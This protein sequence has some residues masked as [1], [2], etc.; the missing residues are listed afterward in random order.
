MIAQKGLSG[1]K[2]IE[3]EGG[4]IKLFDSGIITQEIEKASRERESNISSGRT[5]I[6]GTN[7]FPNGQEEMLDMIE[8]RELIP[9]IGNGINL[10]RASE[11]FEKLRLSTEKVYKK[12]GKKP[13]VFLLPMGN[14]AIRRARAMFATNFFNCAGYEILDKG[15]VESTEEGVNAAMEA[16]ADIVVICGADTAYPDI[17]PP[18]AQGIKKINKSILVI[19]AGYPKAHVDALVNSGVDDFIHISSNIL[20]VLTKYQQHLGILS[21]DY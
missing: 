18:I 17:V 20:E 2:N 13:K 11:S 10:H 16:K 4:F 8:K 3:S 5:S 7:Q 19:V 12:T 14:L 1:F 9:F 21:N 6:L 15:T